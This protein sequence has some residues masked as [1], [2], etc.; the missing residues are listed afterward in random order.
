MLFLLSAN[1]LYLRILYQSTPDRENLSLH[2]N[3]LQKH[4]FREV[5]FLPLTTLI[6]IFQITFNI[7]LNFFTSNR[8]GAGE[9]I[10]PFLSPGYTELD[11]E[12]EATSGVFSSRESTDFVGVFC[13]SYSE[14][15]L[16]ESTFFESLPE[17]ELLTLC[18]SR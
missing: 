12:G 6:V 11:T 9:D 4:R 18:K 7:K 5:R 13:L 2:R 14:L 10:D 8:A 15:S 1:P 3:R 16:S 17:L